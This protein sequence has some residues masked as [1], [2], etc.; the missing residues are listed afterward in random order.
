VEKGATQLQARRT[1]EEPLR[2]TSFLLITIFL[3]LV[4]GIGGVG[5]RF[6]AAE[7]RA[8][9]TEVANQLSAIAA[10][11]VNQVATWRRA[12]WGDA[13]LMQINARMMPSLLEVLRGTANPKTLALMG[14]WLETFCYDLKYANA[15]LVDA[16]GRVRLKA[17]RELG[18]PAHY[19]ELAKQALEAD[20]TVFRD[21]HRDSGL[22]TTHLGLNV[23]LRSADGGAPAGALLLA[24]DPHQYLYPLLESWPTSSRSAETLLVHREGDEIVVLNELRHRSGTA[25]R[26]RLPLTARHLPEVQAVL[27]WEGVAEGVDYRGVPVLAAGRRVPGSPW[28]LVAKMDMAE[29]NA[30]LRLSAFLVSLMAASLIAATGAGVGLLLRHQRLNFYRQKYQSELEHRALLE[31]YQYLT[32]QANDIILLVDADGRILEANQRAVTTYGYARE[33]FVGMDLRQLRDPETL[34]EFQAQWDASQINQG[35]IFETRHRRRDGSCFP[36]EV[37]AREILV[38]GK[39]FRQ[40]FIRD[41]SERKAHELERARLEEQ[42]QQ[43]QKMES[44]GR[45]AGGVAHDFNNHLT[46]INGYCDLLLAGLPPQDALNDPL[47]EI[48]RAGERAAALTKQLLAVSRK[49]VLEPK[50]LNLN[51]VIADVETMLRRLVGGDIEIETQLDPEL[52]TVQADAA[53][54]QQVL[55]NLVVNARDAMPKGGRIVFETLNV[56]LDQAYFGRHADSKTGPHVQLVVSDSG[57]GMNPDTQQHIFEPFFTTKGSGAGAGLGLSTVY[58]IVKQS[59]GWIWVYSEPGRG[60]TF[61]I[62]LPRVESGVEA[63]STATLAAPLGGTETILVVEDQ[64]ELRTLVVEMLKGYGY[65]VLAAANG[66]EALDLCAQHTGPLDLMITDVVMPRMTGRELFD[67]L[68]QSR[69]QV[70]VLYVSGYTANVIA[71]QEVLDSGAAYLPKPFSPEELARKVRQVLAG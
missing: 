27:G 9:Q 66:D 39:L 62:Y 71:H 21:F 5:Y 41:I 59:G 61:K 67:R 34:P 26:M 38:E 23:P 69:S 58:G 24:I 51:T 55:M 49:Q 25:L 33:E 64:E 43:A 56:E 11:K 57:A 37:S 16:N 17:G 48:R 45:L 31:H 4:A 60:T 2:R 54:I 13:R 28:F 15:V 14:A 68:A 10:M 46:V 29:I 22:G 52:G 70:K 36:V 40:S 3:L 30:P 18:A 1:K 12:R 53:Q 65:Q 42:I 19:A 44:V 20:D 32:K 7:K 63:G 47:E 6:Y 50:A 35:M 8:L